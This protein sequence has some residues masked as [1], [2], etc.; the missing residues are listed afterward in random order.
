MH[1]ANLMPPFRKEITGQEEVVQLA[2]AVEIS[3]L[4]HE[5]G[6]SRCLST[7]SEL[8]LLLLPDS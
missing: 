2:V 5:E 4:Q 8:G 6:L 3:F 1:G 7:D